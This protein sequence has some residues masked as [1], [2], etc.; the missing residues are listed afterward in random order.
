MRPIFLVLG[1]SLAL[2]SVVC[3]AELRH[4]EDAPLHAVQ[5]VDKDVGWAIGDDGVVWNTID[6]GK[7]WERQ[8]TGV[9]ATLH[10]SIV[11]FAELLTLST[12]SPTRMASGAS[13]ATAAASI[14]A[15]AS[16]MPRPMLKT[17]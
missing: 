6:G 17:R 4:F 3:A 1:V 9:R 2:P 11:T 15:Q 14:G 7:S 5:F 8:R 10:D 13:R 12:T 16:T